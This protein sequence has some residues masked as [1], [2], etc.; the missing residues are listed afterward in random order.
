MEHTT[1]TQAFLSTEPIN[2]SEEVDIVRDS[3][4]AQDFSEYLA[5]TD[6]DGENE[7]LDL[8][9]ATSGTASSALAPNTTPPGLARPIFTSTY[10]RHQCIAMILIQ[11]RVKGDVSLQGVGGRR[12]LTT[13]ASPRKSRRMSRRKSTTITRETKASDVRGKAEPLE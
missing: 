11:K 6:T 7:S 5:D 10:T 9:A 4:A 8:A 3:V 2:V 12:R 13:S 1:L